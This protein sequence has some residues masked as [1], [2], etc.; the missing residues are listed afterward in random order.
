M[1]SVFWGGVVYLFLH[2]YCLLYGCWFQRFLCFQWCHH[3]L[4]LVSIVLQIFLMLILSLN[5]LLIFLLC[6]THLV[7]L[8]TILL[9][10]LFLIFLFLLILVLTIFLISYYSDF[11]IFLIKFFTVA[12]SNDNGHYRKGRFRRSHSSNKHGHRRSHNSHQPDYMDNRET[13]EVSWS[14]GKIK[15][16]PSPPGACYITKQWICY[17]LSVL[18]TLFWYRFRGSQ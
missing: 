10:I 15:N 11:S 17:P 5:L 9:L 14:V 8:I 6:I 3:F 18:E 12:V 13:V 7:S 1:L 2:C 4:L 16:A